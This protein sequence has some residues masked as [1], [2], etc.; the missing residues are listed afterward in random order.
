MTSVGLN[1]VGRPTP[2]LRWERILKL[3]DTIL[4]VCAWAFTC[5]MIPMSAWS[6]GRR[7]RPLSNQ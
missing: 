5:K 2:G 1:V 7:R 6:E 4:E 3:N